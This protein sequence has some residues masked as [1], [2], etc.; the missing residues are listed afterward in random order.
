VLKAEE[1]LVIGDTCNDHI[2]EGT[3]RGISPE[4]PIPVLMNPEYSVSLGMGYNFIRNM[5]K[6]F[7]E[8]IKNTILNNNPSDIWNYIDKKSG[9]KLLRVDKIQSIV[10]PLTIKDIEAHINQKIRVIVVLDYDS[11]YIT[12]SLLKEISDNFSPY[13]HLYLDTRKECLDGLDG[14]L[15]KINN[16]EY[17]RAS[18]ATKDIARYNIIT[19]YGKAG[20]RYAH[21]YIKQRNP[22]DARDVS[23]CG[24][25]WLS[26]FIYFT[27]NW[28]ELIRLIGRP[29]V[30]VRDTAMDVANITASL[31]AGHL[32]TYAPSKGEIEELYR[33]LGK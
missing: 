12:N 28:E 29:S 10:P 5:E 3:V 2:L 19:T 24:E 13:C 18:K 4:A 8:K 6:L 15:I 16:E 14:W 30:A 11:G 33:R 1:V 23:G 31:T 27:H 22:V 20:A 25:T 26:A 7:G 21:Q 32:G 9:Y 17:S